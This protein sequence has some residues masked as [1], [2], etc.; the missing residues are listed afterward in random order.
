MNQVIELPIWRACNDSSHSREIGQSRSH[1]V[2]DPLLKSTI[3]IQQ[4]WEDE[5]E[6]MAGRSLEAFY[7]EGSILRF[8]VPNGEPTMSRDLKP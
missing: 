7:V 2:D 4:L 3:R 5:I 8:S 6:S 1:F